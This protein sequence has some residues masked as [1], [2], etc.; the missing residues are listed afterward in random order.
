MGE[1]SR[2]LEELNFLCSPIFQALADMPAVDLS[3]VLNPEP[4]LPEHPEKA[5]CL[6]WN[7]QQRTGYQPANVYNL[8]L[9]PRRS[10]FFPW[11]PEPM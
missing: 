6:F 3:L 4:G 2:G 10:P 11:N 5:S 8:Q 7:A 9:Q 1:V